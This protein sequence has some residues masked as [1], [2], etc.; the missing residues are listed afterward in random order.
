MVG[1]TYVLRKAQSIKIWDFVSL[2]TMGSKNTESRKELLM[3]SLALL[4]CVHKILEEGHLPLAKKDLW[5]GHV[6]PKGW[7]KLS[8]IP[9]HP[10]HF[11]VKGPFS[12]LAP[13]QR[14]VCPP[15]CP[16]ACPM[17]YAIIGHFKSM[18]NGVQYHSKHK[19]KSTTVVA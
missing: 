15:T 16:T 1:F 4:V 11:A 5:E 19:L 2:V 8:F 12:G 18:L 6:A 13:P 14:S 7:S 9:N 17:D 10:R 3:A